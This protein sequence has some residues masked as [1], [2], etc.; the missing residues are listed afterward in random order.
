MGRRATVILVGVLAVVVLI[1][2]AGLVW[3]FTRDEAPPVVDLASTVAQVDNRNSSTDDS[4]KLGATSSTTESPATNTAETT[5]SSVA[6]TSRTDTEVS[7]ADPSAELANALD[8][9]WMVRVTE[10]AVD[11]REQP[12]VSFAG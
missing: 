10:G 11:L 5:T 9:V 12:A 7:S 4:K 1:G 6:D 8:G 3:W 2:M